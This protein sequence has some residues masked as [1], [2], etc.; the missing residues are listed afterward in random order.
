MDLREEDYGSFD[1]EKAAPPPERSINAL[2]G[3]HDC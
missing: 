2:S 3:Y 1:I